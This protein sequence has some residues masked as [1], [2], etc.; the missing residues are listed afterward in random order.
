VLLNQQNTN[1]AL[2]NINIVKNFTYDGAVNALGTFGL[3]TS[4]TTTYLNGST[5][6]GSSTTG[7]AL[8]DYLSNPTGVGSAYYIGKPTKV[9]SSSTINNIDGTSDT[10]T[11]EEKYTYNGANIT[12]TEK[13]GHNT[14]YLVEDMTYDAVGNLLTK[15]V[16]MP[17]ASPAIAS[18]T[19]TDEYDPTKRFVKK[20]I[21]YQDF[22]TLI[23][24]NPIG[25]VT[26]STNY[27]GVISNF[28]YDNWG[29]L[30]TSTTTGASTT[31]LVTTTAYV[32][33]S[34]GGYTVTATNTQGDN[35]MSRTQYDVLGRV[36][37]STTKGFGP[38]TEIS[39][40]IEYDALGR[41]YRESE[42]YFGTTIG[43]WA[44][45][46]NTYDYLHR[47]TQ[48]TT[49]TGRVQTL[50]Y[51]G[52]TTTSI[53]DGK[54]TS[55]T[56]N[57]MGNKVSTTDP[58]GTITF[59]YFASG[60]LKNTNYDGNI[61]TNEIDGWGNKLS[62]FDPNAGNP[63]G[64][65]A[66]KYSYTYDAFG[67]VKTETTPKGTTSYSYDGDGKLLTKS[68]IGDGA[69]INT[70]Y[71]YNAYA[72]LET[73]TSKT[74]ANVA[75]DNFGYTYDSLHRLTTTLENNI[76]FNHTKTIGFDSFGRMNIE[77]NVTTAKGTFANNFAS[78][79]ITKYLYN[80]YNGIL[81]KMTD[82]AGLSLWE[83][84]TA[85][86]KMQTLTATLNNGTSAINVS[87]TYNTDFY[88]ATQQH[89]KGA[90]FILNNTYSFD[91]VKGN[92]MNRQN[93]AP[94]MN[95]SEVFT[96]DAQDRLKTWTNPLTAVLDS[97]NYDDK[98]RITTNNK[99]GV[100]SYNTNAATGIY[101]KD[102]IALNTDGLAYYN[103]LAGNQVVTYNMFKSPIQISE[104]GK[105]KCNFEYNSHQ[106][107]SKMLFDNRAIAPSTIASQRKVKLYTDDGSTEIVMDL[108]NN[109]I[110]IITFVGGDAYG[111]VLYNEK[112]RSA[113][114]AIAQ[115][116]NYLHR[117][118]Q[119]T[120]IAITNSTG[121]AIEKRAFDAWGNLCKLERNGVNIT[122][123]LT[124]AGGVVLLLDRGY[125]SHEHL[126][127]VRLIHMNGRLYDPMLRSFLMPDNFV[128]QP[129]NTQ[130]YNRYAYVLN[131][132]LKY[133][134]PSGEELLT[135]ILIG[136]L[137]SAATYTLTALLADVP[138]S[139]GG[140][141][142]ATFIGAA[143]AAV[144]FGIGSAATNTF[145]N[146]YSQ[147]AFQAVAHGTFQGTMTAVSG[148]KFWAG[149]AAGALSSIASSAY[150]GTA[151]DGNGNAIAGTGFKS[152]SSVGGDAGMIAF[153]TIAGGAGAELTG[154]NFWVGAVTGL[155]V[156][157]LNH[158][159][160]GGFAKKYD[161]TSLHDYEAA[162]GAGHDSLAFENEDG[163]QHYV[164]KDGT[165]G[166][167]NGGVFGKSAYTI[168]DFDSIAA[169]NDN[170]AANHGG[171]RY[172]ITGVYRATRAQ[173]IRGITAAESIAKSNYYL[174]GNSCTDV[175]SSGLNAAFGSNFLRLSLKNAI[176]NVN[177]F[178]QP[179]LY[180]SHFTNYNL[181]K[182]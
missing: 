15:T 90:T 58:G 130:N 148:G 150:S 44:T 141:V 53:D 18:R 74:T 180:N 5:V 7:T 156:S 75:I 48:M 111:A 104:S 127:E 80:T 96:Y 11:S 86:Q 94:G 16:S 163:S 95:V 17:T 115:A 56:V 177:F 134:D 121:V 112:T 103:A 91:P 22:I 140:L 9:T 83:L 125:T 32:K 181:L 116:N 136:A 120:I 61:I 87:N 114:G 158:A 113:T 89:K 31:A 59:N 126:S 109:T 6:Q 47:P 169:I 152:L 36:V 51:A 39:K 82:N 34:D 107:R 28:G 172:D 123:P 8:A 2:T 159:M 93:T 12:K 118:Y 176:P 132:P 102:K 43:K 149:F 73:E 142:Q 131:N 106:S 182:K 72:Q 167:I 64:P 137:I 68:V 85:N 42:P 27:L 155:T 1:D 54:T 100:V 50:V 157:A 71:T 170:Y 97:N 128:Q 99:F 160:H 4:T 76:N 13:K 45:T 37:K 14:D 138:F 52:L 65:N 88:F 162:N 35:A 175:L 144:T 3:Q 55:A 57:A 147:A 139:L 84:L 63:T 143:S 161:I 105:G 62:T 38:N 77:T 98:G 179:V 49:S 110:K 66:G 21:D 154:G 40:T 79:V 69:D 146:F 81:Y 129:D 78:T 26:K 168:G 20:K 67:Q 60:Q 124:G 29:K 135:A 24:Y 178:V 119:G 41:K 25:Q 23:E 46:I 92:L 33:L 70:V 30:T 174:I 164:S 173:I 166:N 165:E 133:T 145:T 19:I 151:F 122:I 10:R 117:D 101:R 153:G 108:A 171:K